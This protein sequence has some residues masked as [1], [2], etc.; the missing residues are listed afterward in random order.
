MQAQ[1]RAH[2]VQG[3]RHH[4]PV[5]DDHGPGGRGHVGPRQ[6]P[7]DDLRADAG[8]I[9]HGDA[10]SRS[11][12]AHH[13]VAPRGGARRHGAS[14]RSRTHRSLAPKPP[15]FVTSGQ[16]PRRPRPP[17]R[18]ARARSAG[19]PGELDPAGAEG[20]E[21][22]IQGLA[23]GHDQE[24]GA[25]AGDDP[26]GGPP[27][28]FRHGQPRAGRGRARRRRGGH[29]G[30]A[31]RLDGGG[32]RGE[33]GRPVPC[34]DREHS[35]PDEGVRLGSRGRVEAAAHDQPCPAI[36]KAGAPRSRAEGGGHGPGQPG[37][38]GQEQSAVR[39]RGPRQRVEVARGSRRLA[40]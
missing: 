2:E 9:A 8:R 4:R 22:G 10:E 13:A 38:A 40:R 3:G 6:R 18:P 20:A 33:A 36:R 11:L 14:R 27:E 26:G 29:D 31:A 32:G 21:E 5:A 34:V 12:C 16:R 37:R 24:V 30:R 25:T 23:A 19:A 39:K 17:A 28:R 7:S 1:G 35:R 15:A